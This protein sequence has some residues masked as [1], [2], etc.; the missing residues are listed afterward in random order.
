MVL[1][2]L[3]TLLKMKRFRRDL[4][5]HYSSLQLILYTFEHLSYKFFSYNLLCFIYQYKLLGNCIAYK[6]T[7]I[8]KV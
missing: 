6:E 2:K 8:K 4:T 5:K 1:K 3:Q 7:E